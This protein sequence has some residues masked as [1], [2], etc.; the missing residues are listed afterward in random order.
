MGRHWKWIWFSLRPNHDETTQL[1]DAQKERLWKTVEA[2]L[3]VQ[4]INEVRP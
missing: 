1:S 2:E 4:S 3:A